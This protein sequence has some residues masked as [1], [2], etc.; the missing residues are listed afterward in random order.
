MATF[1]G[2][3]LGAGRLDRIRDGVRKSEIIIV[4]VCI[5]NSFFIIMF[6]KYF[7]QLFITGNDGQEVLTLAQQ[8]LNTVVIFFIPLG[9]I[10]IYRNVLQGLGDGF[11]PMMGGVLELV[12]RVVIALGVAPILGYTAICY[13]GPF[14]WI[15]AAVLLIVMYY[16]KFPKLQKVGVENKTLNV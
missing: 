13:S 6:G 15:V 9:L 4:I 8:Y 11:M 12:A 2:Q 3:N 10:F 14:S 1:T 16:I 5:I 7:L